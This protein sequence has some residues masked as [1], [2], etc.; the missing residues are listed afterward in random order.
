M[1]TKLRFA[2]NNVDFAEQNITEKIR[3]ILWFYFLGLEWNMSLSILFLLD[4]MC[5]NSVTHQWNMYIWF[6]KKKKVMKFNYIRR[7]ANS[8]LHFH[9]FFRRELY[10][11][12]RKSPL[13]DL[14]KKLIT[15]I[16]TSKILLSCFLINPISD[17]CHSS[18]WE[19]NACNFRSVNARIALVEGRGSYR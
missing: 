9:S 17:E 19:T 6:K 10:L 18:N 15:Y 1:V 16:D 12:L 5:K 8:I 13:K 4:T 7:W 2:L 14:K 3:I 11:I